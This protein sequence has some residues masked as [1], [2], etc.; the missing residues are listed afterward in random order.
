[1]GVVRVMVAVP[2]PEE[3]G[4]RRC[5]TPWLDCAPSSAPG[6]RLS[7]GG[8]PVSVCGRRSVVVMIWSFVKYLDEPDPSAAGYRPDSVAQYSTSSPLPRR[9]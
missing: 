2:L 8:C 6:V 1:V 4:S 9:N 3:C 5:V 7:V